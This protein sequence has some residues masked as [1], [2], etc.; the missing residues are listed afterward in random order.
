MENVVFP[1]GLI[2]WPL[3]EVPL[4]FTRVVRSPEEKKEGLP[5]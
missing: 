1:A 3:L 5:R 4:Y 2:K